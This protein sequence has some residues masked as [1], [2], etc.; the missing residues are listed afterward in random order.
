MSIPDESKHPCT[1]DS[2]YT[3]G[4]TGMPIRKL[5]PFCE[6]HGTPMKTWT[7]YYEESVRL[8]GPV[9][10][11]DLVDLSKLVAHIEYATKHFCD[12]VAKREMEPIRGR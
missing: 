4:G 11:T 8:L 10:G 6:E 12:D 9:R 3:G 7:D 5:D 1:C 2:V